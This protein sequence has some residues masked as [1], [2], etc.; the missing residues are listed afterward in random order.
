MLRTTTRI[1]TRAASG[2]RSITPKT[3]SF[4]HSY[5]HCEDPFFDKESPKYRILDKA[6][7]YVPKYG[8]QHKAILESSRTFG[9]SDAIQSL[10]HNG[11][12][13]LIKFH[14]IRERLKL[15]EYADLDDF[16]L[17]SENDKVKYLVKKRLEGNIPYV[18]HINQLQ[19]YLVL[20][21]NIGESSQEL[22]N[23]SDDIRFYSGDMTNDF[24][25]YSKRLSLSSSYVALE[26]FM[27]QDKSSNFTKTM[28][29]AD[30]RLENI[31]DLG[32]LY[33]DA[34]EF[35]F[36]TLASGANLVKSQLSRS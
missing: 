16:K 3:L 31:G 22:H 23:L 19:T 1:T 27:A 5:E 33:K 24:A 10:F 14:L 18:E 17:L 4:Y 8:F 7:E 13:D 15:K 2:Y 9:Y 6:M 11:T 32:Q 30:K 28:E 29:L 25:W 20:P 26:L 36:Y 21:P 35:F 12:F 34:E